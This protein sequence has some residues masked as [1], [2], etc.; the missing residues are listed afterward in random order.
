MG[1]ANMIPGRSKSVFSSVEGL[2]WIWSA[3]DFSLFDPKIWGMGII[4]KHYLGGG[5]K[6]F[7]FSPRNLGTWWRNLTS[8]F[9]RW[10]ETSSLDDH[11]IVIADPLVQSSRK[12]TLP[13]PTANPWKWMVGRLDTS[14]RVFFFTQVI[15]IPSKKT[16]LLWKVDG[17]SGLFAPSWR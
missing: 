14:F 5:F 3:G 12:T 4:I 13:E 7:L 15:V 2:V 6:Y 17:Q 8:I 9:F 10:V 11:Y 16:S 1:G